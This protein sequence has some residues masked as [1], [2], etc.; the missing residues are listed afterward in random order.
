MLLVTC[1]SP[2]VFSV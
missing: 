2:V 1:G